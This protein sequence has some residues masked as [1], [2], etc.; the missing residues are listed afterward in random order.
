MSE[1]EDSAEEVSAQGEETNSTD[2]CEGADDLQARLEEAEREREQFKGIAARAQ[3]DR[4]NYRRRADEEKDEIRRT[5]KSSLLTKI[6]STVDDLDR[7]LAM[8]P[9]EESAGW[10]E[11]IQLVRRNLVGT[12]DS[13]GVTRLESLG[14]P[15]DPAYAEALQFRETEDGEE[16]TVVEVYKEGYMYRD[17]VLR[18]AQVVVAKRPEQPE[19][20]ESNETNSDKEIG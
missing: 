5:A 8:I 3:A 2:D 13:E 15:Y 19:T 4:V 20:T 17:R 14:N 12:L 18:A 7:A 11:G 6:I 9:S 10:A 16:G 1:H